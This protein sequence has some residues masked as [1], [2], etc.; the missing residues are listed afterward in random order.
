MI[1]MKELIVAGVTLFAFSTPSL[2]DRC[3]IYMADGWAISG[4]SAIKLCEDGKFEFYDKNLCEAGKYSYN[5][6]NN[7]FFFDEKIASLYG[8][9]KRQGDR[10]GS[11]SAEIKDQSGR[12]KQINWIL[13][14][15]CNPWPN[16]KW[17]KKKCSN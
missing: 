17:S 2:A 13:S 6:N 4:E 15:P 7:Q 8:V 9:I 3:E 1:S 16:C 10:R 14:Q 12:K 5:S 11:L